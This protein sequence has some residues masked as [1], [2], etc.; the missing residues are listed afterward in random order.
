MP[1]IPATATPPSHTQGSSAFATTQDGRQLHYQE[2]PGPGATDNTG[3]GYGPTLVFDAGMAASRSFWGL[4][5]PQCAQW[6]RSI[7]YDRSGL[8]RSPADSQPRTIERMASDLNELLDHLGAGPFILIAHSGSGLIVRAATAAC[9][10][11]IA[12][13][14]LVDVT[15]E[16]C[17][18]VFSPT[19]R[20]MEKAAH[21]ASVLLARLG[22][23]EACYR[24][25]IAGLPAD[26]RHDLS[27]E[28]FT[29]AVMKTRAAELQG[30][31]DAMHAFRHQ[32]PRL[33]DIPVSVISGMQA[34]FGMSKR[35]RAAANGAHRLRAAHCRQGRF[36]PARHSGHAV[37]LSEP[38]LVANE[39]H[40]L[41]RQ[42]PRH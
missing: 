10:A 32:P 40:H 7:A 29:R 26:V 34:D 37:L 13:L 42:H 18:P 23:L 30:L 28:G 8:G 21:G 38:E 33:P 1:S 20:L 17:T 4:V 6:A 14:V 39:I 35:L 3:A 5:Q 15:D 25:A 16:G 19:F 2:L 24:S 41:L 31:V 11:R 12:G 27:R 36:I 9:P 22:L